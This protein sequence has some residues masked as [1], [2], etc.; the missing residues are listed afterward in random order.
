MTDL[1][2]GVDLGGTKIAAVALADDGG[3][4]GDER[5]EGNSRWHGS[6]IRHLGVLGDNRRITPRRRRPRAAGGMSR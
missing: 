4:T 6:E 3:E 5:G 2:W 1:C